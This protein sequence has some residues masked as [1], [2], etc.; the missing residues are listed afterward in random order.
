MIRLLLVIALLLP[1][2]ALAA[3]VN[4]WEKPAITTLPDTAKVSVYD[5]SVLKT[6]TGPNLK[7]DVIDAIK[8][9]SSQVIGVQPAPTAGAYERK[10]EVKDK[11]GLI[12][13][14]INASGTVV[15]A[16]QLVLGSTPVPLA[17]SSVAP[18]NGATAQ[19][20]IVYPAVTF[21]KGVSL[22]LSTMYIQGN[23]TAPVMGADG[24]T[25]NIPATLAYG[26]TY[27][28]KVV[29]NSI[30]QTDGETSS[31]C[32][33][34]MADVSGVC[35]STFTTAT[36]GISSVVPAAGATGV[37]GTDGGAFTAVPSTTFSTHALLTAGAGSFTCSSSYYNGSGWVN[38]TTP[39]DYL[40]TNSLTYTLDSMIYHKSYDASHLTTYTC[41]IVKSIGLTTCAAGTSDTG[42]TCRWT[43]TTA[44]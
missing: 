5:G 40:T 18:A 39:G 33:T 23:S 16:G 37:T 7:T 15:I 19:S 30:L 35:Q 13:M 43:F 27:T 41:D 1:V 38:D 22:S 34:T 4:P 28:L 14:Y 44:Q 36:L 2:Q 31:S 10:F 26:T 32:G 8:L 17:V 11:D 25:W 24:A 21:N 6:I 9:P 20:I 12:K 3:T 42:S 29:K